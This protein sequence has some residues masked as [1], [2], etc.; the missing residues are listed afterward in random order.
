MIN[1]TAVDKNL[2]KCFTD[3]KHNIKKHTAVID[4]FTIILNVLKVV[5]FFGKYMQQF[6]INIAN[7][8]ELLVNIFHKF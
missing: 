1:V 7:K 8:I 4:I 5:S 2:V 6:P 3:I